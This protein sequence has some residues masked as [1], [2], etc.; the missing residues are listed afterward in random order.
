MITCEERENLGILWYENPRP[1]V[2][3]ARAAWKAHRVAEHPT[4]DVELGDLDSLYA[5]V[6][7]QLGL[8][9]RGESPYT[10]NVEVINLDLRSLLDVVQTIAKLGG[11]EVPA[12]WNGSS[13]LPWLDDPDH[14]WK[15]AAASEYY[16]HNIASGF[17]MLRSGRYK[18]VYHTAPD[19]GHPAERELYDLEADPGEFT[20]LARDPAHA[21][22][23]K[24]MHAAL[25]R[26]IGED[27]D[28][29]ERRC[30]AD[31]A[32]GYGRAKGSKGK[33][34]KRKGKQGKKG[35]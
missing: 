32:R 6:G 35:E 8:H 4:H 16:A 25:V 24:E 12:D 31:Y 15:D 11:A 2:D 30:R 5:E 23:I 26:E 19:A 14:A 13:M 29:T 22:R 10:H 1:A 17:A 34:K 9:S 18:Y 28:Q 3:P 7:A 27:P 33:G 20:N 21:R